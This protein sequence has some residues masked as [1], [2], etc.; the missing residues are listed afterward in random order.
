MPRDF[1]VTAFRETV[2]KSRRRDGVFSVFVEQLS[3]LRFAALTADKTVCPDGS[4][5]MEAFFPKSIDNFLPSIP[6]VA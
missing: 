3:D 5:G 1:L 6:T 4:N 2:A